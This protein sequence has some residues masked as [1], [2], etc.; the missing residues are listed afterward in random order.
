MCVRDYSAFEQS[1]LLQLKVR[2]TIFKNTNIYTYSVCVWKTYDR[3]YI[4]PQSL[5]FNKDTYI[6]M[7]LRVKQS[8]IFFNIRWMQY[9]NTDC[10]KINNKMDIILKLL[11]LP[12]LFV[13]LIFFSL[14]GKKNER[15]W[16][17]IDH[18]KAIIFIHVLGSIF[19]IY[20]YKYIN[21]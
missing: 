1:C 7:R 20:K 3:Y 2:I 14:S 19:L 4:F 15:L 17:Q 6:F 8:Y 16:K 10:K 11:L 13:L 12:N 5:I 18:I 21:I 9:K